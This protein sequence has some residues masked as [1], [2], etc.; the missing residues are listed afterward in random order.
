MHQKG[1]NG[2]WSSPLKLVELHFAPHRCL[3]GPIIT[4][5]LCLKIQKY[6]GGQICRTAFCLAP[7]PPAKFI[8]FYYVYSLL[9]PRV[10]SGLQR[11]LDSESRKANPE[12]PKM[13]AIL[14]QLD[15]PNEIQNRK[16]PDGTE[17]CSWLK[18]TF[19]NWFLGSAFRDSVFFSFETP[20]K[21][22]LSHV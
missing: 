4:E 8:D 13:N 2:I 1:V 15:F 18:Y 9:P 3:C 7:G 19:R 20:C 10:D 16:R 22:S 5:I 11:R 12:K 14:S 17:K 6:V 21:N